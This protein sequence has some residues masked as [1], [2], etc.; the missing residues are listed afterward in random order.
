[1]G[2]SML[3][4]PC[5]PADAPPL[6]VQPPPHP[7]RNPMPTPTRRRRRVA[8]A[9]PT[10]LAAEQ[11]ELKR[12]QAEWQAHPP[13]PEELEAARHFQAKVDSSMGLGG[14]RIE[15]MTP[16]ESTPPPPEEEAIPYCVGSVPSSTTPKSP[17]RTATT[18]GAIAWRTIAWPSKWPTRS[19]TWTASEP[20]G[21]GRPPRR[22]DA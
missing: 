17:V 2:N 6:V 4:T 14:F 19:G 12:L 20:R 3:D 18:A 21:Q 5:P 11:R 8:K 13:S 7:E 1:M 9:A 10:G 15:P 16:D 22:P